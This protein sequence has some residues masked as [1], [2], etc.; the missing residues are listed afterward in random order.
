MAHGMAMPAEPPSHDPVLRAGA[1][2]VYAYTTVLLCLFGSLLLHL[3][4]ATWWNGSGPDRLA[5]ALL[6]TLGTSVVSTV[7]ALGLALP[8]AWRMVRAP[9]R[10]QAVIDALVDLPM[11]VSPLV[12]GMAFVMVFATGPGRWLEQA[13][14][15]A[16]LPLRGA[17]AGVVLRQ[18]VLAPPFAQRHLRSAL[19][20]ADGGLGAALAARRGGVLVAATITWARTVGEFGPMLL[21]VGIVPGGSEVLST[22]I[23]AA[24]SA[25]DLQ[26]AALAALVMVGLSFLVVFLIRRLGRA[27]H[28]PRP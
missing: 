26:A 25:G 3:P 28:R 18:T 9:V 12:M 6:L 22:A 13:A 5:E 17:V 23:Y 7:L 19:A 1:G 14:A 10:G 20:G 27:D 21:F 8:A 16:G 2:I 24:W 15:A 4:D 11:S